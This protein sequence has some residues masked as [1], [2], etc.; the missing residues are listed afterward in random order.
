MCTT[1]GR[2]AQFDVMAID[3]LKFAKRL[4]EAGFSD[5]QAEALVATVQEAAEGSDLVTKAD[6]GEA[7]AELETE[8]SELRAELKA[9]ISELRAELKADIS[10]L[11]ADV[12]AVR[13]ELREVELR[14][15]AR[16]EAVKADILSRVFGLI[17]GA[18]VVNV[19]AIVGA[20]FGVAKLLGH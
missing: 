17:L 10:E 8:I 18:V 4:R 7:R 15:Q 5:P 9:D 1:V 11:K 19:V 2:A 20:M 16:L 6:L 12:A 13:S 3:T 14:F